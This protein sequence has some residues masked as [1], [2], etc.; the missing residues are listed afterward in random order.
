[1]RKILLGTTMLVA[2]V[3]LSGQAKAEMEVTVGGFANA[4]AGFFDNDVANSSS[5]DFTSESEIHV[6]ANG[7]AEN[8]L[9]YGAKVELMTS[10]SDSTNSDE[11]GLY[12]SGNWGRVELGDDDGASDQLTVLAPTVGIGQIDGRYLDFVPSADRPSGNVKDT[13][14]G[15]MKPLDT[16]DATK[17]TYYTPRF[18]GFQAGVSY[19]PESDSSSDGEQV[20]F[21]DTVGNQHNAYELGLQYR[22]QFSDVSVRLGAGYVG[23]DAKSGSGR[24]DVRSWGLG[25]QLTYAGFTFGGGYVSNGDSNNTAGVADD[26]ESAWNTGLRYKTDT[27]GVAVSYIDEDYNTAGGRGTNTDGGDFSALVLGATYKVADGL[28]TSADLS[29]YDRNRV[30]GTDTNGYV[31]VVETKASF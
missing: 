20:Q 16:D 13:G 22:R 23:S 25:G 12:V 6:K 26:G 1:M 18:E 9:E 3:A 31:F 2:V 8:G 29:F 5:R 24:E 11:A 17:V 28:S 15:N 14:G 21:F 4:R 30:T 19:A 7:V 10:T 27:W